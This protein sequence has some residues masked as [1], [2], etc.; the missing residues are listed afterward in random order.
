MDPREL[1]LGEV[2]LGEIWNKIKQTEA[3]QPPKPNNQ[4]RYDTLSLKDIRTSNL[5]I[6]S[7]FDVWSQNNLEKN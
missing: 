1:N 4:L 7:P 3:A 5:G 2:N 6:V